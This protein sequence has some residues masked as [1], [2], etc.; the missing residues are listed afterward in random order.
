MHFQEFQMSTTIPSYSRRLLIGRPLVLYLWICFP[1]KL[2]KGISEAG[3]DTDPE[4]W[5]PRKERSYYR[6]KRKDKRKDV[7]K[8][9]QGLS[10]A[11]KAF[12][13][14]LDASEPS[15][16][17]S[18]TASP[19]PSGDH[20][21]PQVYVIHDTHTYKHTH[22]H[23]YIDTHTFNTTETYIPASSYAELIT[24]HATIIDF[25]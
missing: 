23:T 13:D 20:T 24:H 12:A 5:L 21:S 22:I 8:G 3:G 18:E 25:R 17:T 7:G 1:G 19:R 15:P 4:R 14:S 6:G 9:T 2:P 16:S 10:A 11:D